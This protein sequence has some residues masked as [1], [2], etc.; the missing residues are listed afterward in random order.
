MQ[1]ERP[2]LERDKD[3]K[4]TIENMIVINIHYGRIFLFFL[5]RDVF[6]WKKKRLGQ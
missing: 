3:R 6:I 4:V 1:V 2:L 5:F